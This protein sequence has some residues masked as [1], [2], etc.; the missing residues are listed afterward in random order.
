MA[1]TARNGIDLHSVGQIANLPDPTTAQQAATKN[2]VDTHSFIKRNTR[3]TAATTTTATTSATAQKVMEL[4]APMVTGHLYQIYTSS[5]EPFGTA[6]ATIEIQLTYTVDG[7][8]PAVT[9]TIL[10]KADVQVISGGIPGTVVLTG[11]YVAVGSGTLKVLLSYFCAVGATTVGLT[12]GATFPMDIYIQD[13]GTD[14]GS[15][16]TNF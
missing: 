6:A 1:L 3:T 5:L 15:T 7:T 12:A 9:S 4:D 13:C 8:T 14:P 2:Y 11:R 10:N 16:G